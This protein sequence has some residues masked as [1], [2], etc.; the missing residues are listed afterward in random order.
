[1]IERL[2]IHRGT[3]RKRKALAHISCKKSSCHFCLDIT[4]FVLLPQFWDVSLFFK[5]PKV[6]DSKGPWAA[7][8]SDQLSLDSGSLRDPFHTGTYYCMSLHFL[9]SFS[10]IVS[11]AYIEPVKNN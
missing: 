7:G 4:Y 1:M 9:K 6:A 8:R 10:I 2:S 3:L 5:G 11:W